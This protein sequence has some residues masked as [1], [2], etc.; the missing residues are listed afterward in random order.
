MNSIKIPY[1]RDINDYTLHFGKDIF[2]E[3]ISTIKKF[4]KVVIITDSNVKTLYGN[5]LLAVLKHK[6]LSA[7]LLSFPAGESQKN[8][9]TKENLENI[10]LSKGIGRNSCILALGGGVVGDLAGF[11]AAT[12]MRGITYIQ[13][14]TTLLA[15]VDSSIGGKT[16]VDTIFGK[17]MI[18]SFYAPLSVFIDVSFLKTLSEAQIKNGMAEMI[19]HSIIS[20]K[21]YFEFLYNT[22][23]DLKSLKDESQVEKAIIRSCEIKKIFVA[24]D[25]L[26]KN[27]R[28]ALNFGHTVGHAVEHVSAYSISHG[29]AVAMGIVAE[30]YMAKKMN[31]LKESD[32]VLI[33][34]MIKKLGFEVSFEEYNITDIISATKFDK[35][36]SNNKVNYVLPLAIGKIKIDTSVEDSFVTSCL[37][38]LK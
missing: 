14:P 30:S 33:N 24:K 13:I 15:M 26:E 6:N 2:N 31:L 21:K 37:G 8:R 12:Y 29:Q 10:M 23:E 11:I 35:K 38:E 4:E 36:N 34:S 28:K 32:Y 3:I 5:S 9:K 16:G 27:V 19:K 7:I 1:R 18:G 20:D 22:I 25:N 17:N